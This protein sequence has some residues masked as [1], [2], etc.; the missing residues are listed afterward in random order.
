MIEA[1]ALL[2]DL[3]SHSGAHA[4]FVAAAPILIIEQAGHI[5]LSEAWCYYLEL[6]GRVRAI[7]L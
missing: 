7:V 2:V 1:V 6:R 5:W 4:V 3:P